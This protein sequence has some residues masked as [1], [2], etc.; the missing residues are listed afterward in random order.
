MGK[1]ARVRP[2]RNY[3]LRKYGAVHSDPKLLNLYYIVIKDIAE[4]PETTIFISCSISQCHRRSRLLHV[5]I[6]R[7][8]SSKRRLHQ[9][10]HHRRLSLRHF[11]RDHLERLV[12][13]FRSASDSQA[14]SYFEPICLFRLSGEIGVAAIAVSST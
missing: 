13:S 14:P 4:S 5:N 12:D 9:I 11:T 3:S 7:N 10:R 2:A 6:A 1:A 8:D